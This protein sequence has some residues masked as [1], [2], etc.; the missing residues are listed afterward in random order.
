MFIYHFFVEFAPTFKD[1]SKLE[2]EEKLKQQHKEDSDEETL[3]TPLQNL[4]V[5][6][7]SADVQACSICQE[8]FEKYWEEDEEEWMYLNIIKVEGDNASKVK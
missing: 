6:G 1:E 3:N 2:H 7:V 5:D 4:P 8:D